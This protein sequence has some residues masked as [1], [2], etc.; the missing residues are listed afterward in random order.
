MILQ[1]ALR[2]KSQRTK[3]A[4]VLLQASVNIFMFPE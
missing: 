1:R 3:I 2:G 4:S